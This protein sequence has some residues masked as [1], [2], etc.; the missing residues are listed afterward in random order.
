MSFLSVNGP[1]TV[2]TSLVISKEILIKDNRASVRI[3]VFLLRFECH[4]QVFQLR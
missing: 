3:F 1:A 4:Y 2:L